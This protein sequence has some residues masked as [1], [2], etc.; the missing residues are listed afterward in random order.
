MELDYATYAA[1]T[2]P[3][4]SHINV[5]SGEDLSI[6]ELAEQIGKTVGFKGR[7]QFDITKPDG[8]PRKLMNVERL[9]SLGWRPRVN[10]QDGLAL[11][12]RDFLATS[13]L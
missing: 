10:L 8:T 4:L 3:M 1:N 6:K 2:K 13:R 12:Y 5:G 11:A 7:I 9:N